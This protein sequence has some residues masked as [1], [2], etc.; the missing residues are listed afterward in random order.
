MD[1]SEEL[2]PIDIA[3]VEKLNAAFAGKIPTPKDL[4]T[5]EGANSLIACVG[6]AD[7]NVDERRR[8]IQ[9]ACEAIDA[10]YGGQAM[11]VFSF[12][13]QGCARDI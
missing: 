2:L 13:F 10:K 5:I 6:G 7:R 3:L 12:S 8:Y 9:R 11:N 4:R 1:F